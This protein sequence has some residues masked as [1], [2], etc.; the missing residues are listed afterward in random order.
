MKGVWVHPGST[1]FTRIPMPANCTAA[2]RLK[3]M[4]AA[5]DD[6]DTPYAAIPRP[7]HAP[8]FNDYA[9]LARLREWGGE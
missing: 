9:H 1:A 6:P 2:E 3:A 7:G 4:I 8:R 5:F